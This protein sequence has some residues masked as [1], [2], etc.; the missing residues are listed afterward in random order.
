LAG[1]ERSGDPLANRF[2]FVRAGPST[3]EQYLGY[4]ALPGF[5]QSA[6]HIGKGNSSVFHFDGQNE[7]SVF[8]ETLKVSG[9][10]CG[11]G[12]RRGTGVF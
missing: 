10:A 5:V 2:P 9:L 6:L 11:F 12:P 4:L 3:S 7:F 8:V 1:C